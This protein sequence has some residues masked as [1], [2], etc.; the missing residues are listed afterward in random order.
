MDI[1]SIFDQ[2]NH[3]SAFQDAE[4]IDSGH[5]NTTYLVR[6]EDFALPDYIL[7]KINSEVFKNIPDLIQNK[8]LVTDFL[9]AKASDQEKENIIRLIPTKT[10]ENYY[11]DSNK[12]YWNLMAFIPNSE[13]YLMAKSTKIAAEAGRLFGQFFYLLNDFEAKKLTETIPRFHDM[14][15]RL[16]QFENSL[17]Q[18]NNERLAL[19][20]D[21]IEFVK[22]NKEKTLLLQELKN[23]GKLPLRVTH[24]DTKISNALFNTKGKGLAVIDLDT[25]MPGLVHY[26]FGDSVRTI[27]SSAEEDEADME[28]VYFI[29]EKFKA[30]AGGFLN[31]CKSI[32]KE[33]E[34]AHLVLGVEYMVFI[35]GLRFLTDYLNNDIYFKTKYPAHNLVRARNQFALLKSMKLHG[36]EMQEI[37]SEL[38]QTDQY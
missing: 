11:I 33:E 13:V 8:I 22:K 24:N 30:F 12:D 25:L 17:K 36:Q 29:P 28:N 32:L 10:G 21:S 34:I 37:I 6:T 18:A 2:F 1:E 23:M 15:H 31:A 38:T 5:I 35:I 14:E 26:D 3:K 4:P 20:Q 7:Q 19:A 9:R 16:D 27:C